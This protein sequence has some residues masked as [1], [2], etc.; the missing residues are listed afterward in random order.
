LPGT[1]DGEGDVGKGFGVAGVDV[2][3][4]VVVE[5]GTGDTSPVVCD[6]IRL[7]EHERGGGVEVGV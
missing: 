5:V 6:N 2:G 3:L 7:G 4:L 1:V